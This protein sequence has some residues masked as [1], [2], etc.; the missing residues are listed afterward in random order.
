MKAVKEEP[1]TFPTSFRLSREAVVALAKA[2]RLYRM[3]RADLIEHLAK[4]A[5]SGTRVEVGTEMAKLVIE[6]TLHK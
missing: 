5:I 6:S 2:S 4:A 3:S 1:M